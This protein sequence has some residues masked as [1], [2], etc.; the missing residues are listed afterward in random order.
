MSILTAMAKGQGQ[1][2]RRGGRGGRKGKKGGGGVMTGMRSGFKNVANA[3]TGAEET[4]KKS[5]WI[6]TALLIVVAGLA[7]YVFLRR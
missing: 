1:R 4:T 6:V 5:S 7:A 3:V 2:K